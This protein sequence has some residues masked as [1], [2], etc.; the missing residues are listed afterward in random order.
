MRKGASAAATTFTAADPKAQTG[1]GLGLVREVVAARG[2][3]ILA[4]RSDEGGASVLMVLPVGDRAV[5]PDLW[6]EDQ[7]PDELSSSTSSLRLDGTYR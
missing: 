7:D 4:G 6:S 1:L 2:G 3:R 5:V